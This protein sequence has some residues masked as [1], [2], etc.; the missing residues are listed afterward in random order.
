MIK[1]KSKHEWQVAIP[2]EK[3]TNDDI[4]DIQA[5]CILKFGNAGKKRDYRWRFGW[6]DNNDVF[7][8]REQAD[9]AMFLLVWGK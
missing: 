3:Y 7:Y 1:R 6:I 4:R 8:F 9:A 2:R 5:W